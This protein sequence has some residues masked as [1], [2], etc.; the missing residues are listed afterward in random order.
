MWFSKQSN[1]SQRVEVENILIMR[2][3]TEIRTANDAS[4]WQLSP[5]LRKCVD[6]GAIRYI[7]PESTVIK[8]EI[9]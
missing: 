1:Q 6:K 2:E 7:R 9:I 5:Y 8:K 3:V 4:Y